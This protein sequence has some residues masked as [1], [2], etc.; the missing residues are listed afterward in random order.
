MGSLTPQGDDGVTF[1]LNGLPSAKA[2]PRSARDHGLAVRF[3]RSG[4]TSDRIKVVLTWL[5]IQ[6]PFLMGLALGLVV[7]VS[8]PCDWV[9]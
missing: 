9:R 5:P 3:T 4:H 8:I 7:P 1:S 6:M 2:S